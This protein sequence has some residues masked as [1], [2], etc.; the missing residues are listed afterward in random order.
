MSKNELEKYFGKNYKKDP[1]ELKGLNTQQKANLYAIVKK[2]RDLGFT[3]DFAIAAL[4]SI[5]SKESAFKTTTEGSY[6]STNAK[7]IREVFGSQRTSKYKDAEINRFKSKDEDFFDFVYGWIAKG[8]GFATY[9]N[10]NP[11][12]GYRYRGRGFNQLTFKNIYKERGQSVGL[13]LVSKPELLD[14]PENAAA[15]LIEYYLNS[16]KGLSNDVAN[17]AGVKKQSSSLLTINSLSNLEVAVDMFYLATLGNMVESNYDKKVLSKKKGVVNNS[18]GTLTF[19]NDDLGGYTKARNRAPYFYLLISGKPLPDIP[20]NELPDDRVRSSE[21]FGVQETN[22]QD[23]N[24]NPDSGNKNNFEFNPVRLTQII[25]PTIELTTIEVKTDQQNKTKKKQFLDGMGQGPFIYYNGIHIEYTDI[26]DFKLYH[27][28][29]IPAMKINFFDRNGIFADEGFPMDDAIITVFIYS[30]SNRLRSVKMDFKITQFQDLFNNKFSISGICSI[31]EIYL[32]RIE[33]FSKST[34]FECLKEVAKICKLGFCSN[35]SNSDDE[36]NWINVGNPRYEF[37]NEVVKSSYISDESFLFC[38]ID[39]YYNLCYVDIEKELKRD[40]SEDKMI[41]SDG[42]EKDLAKDSDDEK[43]ADLMLSTDKSFKETNGFIEEYKVTNR[44]TKISLKKGYYT[45]VDY[46]DTVNKNILEFNIDTLTS[47]GKKSII[48]KGKPLDNDYFK[49]N[50]VKKWVGKLEPFGDGD[51]NMHENYQYS[52]IQNELNLEELTKIQLNVKLKTPNYNLFITQK[53]PAYLTKDKPGLGHSSLNYKRLD[54]EWIITN[55]EYVFDGKSQYQ[56]ITLVKRELELEP[57]EISEFDSPTN[58]NNSL[59]NDS[60]QNY[61]NELS[62]Y[63]L[64][65]NDPLVNETLNR[66]DNPTLDTNNFDLDYIVGH[67]MKDNS[68]VLRTL[69]VI[70]GSAV[71]EKVGIAFLKMQEVARKDGV[72]ISINSGFR[73]AFGPNFKGK[74]SKGK[75]V[76]ITTQ[77]TLR[78]DKSRWITSE[79]AKFTNDEDFIFKARSSAYNPQTAPPGSSN[80]G[81]GIALDLNSGSR[82]S[83]KKVLNNKIYEWLV[84]NSW[85]FGFVRAVKTEEWH[86]EY[87]PDVSQKGP[88]AL[89]A[90]GNANLFYSDLGLDKLSL[91]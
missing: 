58:S 52:I 44:S 23:S 7:R 82:V 76:N 71:D 45:I 75:S 4:L 36:M 59:S 81:N 50:Y 69:I 10:D 25:E 64:P 33:S 27:E 60:D 72:K 37:I 65:P 6:K 19:P 67:S 48:L 28:G 49:E 1:S 14:L 62:P 20:P 73:P 61:T 24:E 46:Y 68:G 89:F 54:G 84:R 13:D 91:A 12:D 77:E 9:G 43:I 31:P 57:N 80:H 16:F 74:T 11:G 56:K 55:I 90:G 41:V 22:E 85:K 32:S 42:K 21:E 3:N 5:V 88:Y 30:R 17:S 8:N 34:S 83:L 79:R 39:F 15:V 18:D 87:R 47:D 63:D 66:S 53:V 38:Y 86:F 29:I 2:S 26:L 70:D 35:I 51:G 40:I 78:R